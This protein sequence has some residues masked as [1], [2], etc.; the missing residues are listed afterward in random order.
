MHNYYPDIRKRIGEEPTWYDC[1]GTPRYGEFE[2][3]LNP[4]IYAS[5]VILVQIS[6]QDCRG[7]FLVEMNWDTMKGLL[8]CG[9]HY[10]SFTTEISKWLAMK[11]KKSLWPPVHYGDPPAHGC[12][13]DTMNCYDLK[14]AQFWRKDNMR[15]VRVPE[16]EVELEKEDDLPSV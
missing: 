1:N 14:I 9:R 12:V 16:L 4:N 3:G 2:P 13:G 5:E 11:D 8:A 15:W 7:R 10:E 6:C